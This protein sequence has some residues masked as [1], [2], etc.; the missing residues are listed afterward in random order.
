MLPLKSRLSKSSRSSSFSLFTL[1]VLGA[2]H[3][4]LKS[5]LPLFEK[6]VSPV[7][8][9]RGQQVP[10]SAIVKNNLQN[11]LHFSAAKL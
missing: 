8:M 10:P 3:V 9:S 7:Q 1:L 4:C 6:L 11:Y 5:L 2:P